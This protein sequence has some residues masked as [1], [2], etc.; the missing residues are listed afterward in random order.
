MIGR[1]AFYSEYYG[2]RVP[3][4]ELVV[5]R[6]REK[7]RERGRE[8]RFV[9]LVGDSSM[10]NK[11]WLGGWRKAVNGYED[12]LEPPTSRPDVAYWLNK[13]EEEEYSPSL[14]SSPLSPYMTINAAVEESTVGGREELEEGL[15]EQDLFVRRSLTPS[16]VVI[17]SVGGNDLALRLSP[18]TLFHSFLYVSSFSSS[19][20][21]YPLRLLSPWS[22]NHL[23]SILGD[24]VERY[25]ERL[26][27]EE[28]GRPKKVL[29]CM[30]YYPCLEEG[31]WAG[32]LLG[33]LGYYQNPRLIQSAIER[34][35]EKATW[36][37]FFFFF[38]S[39]DNSFPQLISYSP[40]PAT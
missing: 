8:A 20:L 36:L 4:L 33:K 21:T 7:E 1:E 5:E 22:E 17:A 26:V 35:Y 10:D 29:V 19:P 24:G 6:R 30:I 18:L 11:Y 14:S 28:G 16:D 3:H 27:G 23:S 39:K 37:V 31:G 25:V 40:F 9:Y 34:L 12:V 13:L 15:L 38:F 2:H 32:K